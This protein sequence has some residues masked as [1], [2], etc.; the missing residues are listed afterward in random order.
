MKRFVLLVTLLNLSVLV[1]A[2]DFYYKLPKRRGHMTEREKAL[3]A[4]AELPET[5]RL[6]ITSAK[7]EPALNIA[8]E[9]EPGKPYYW[10]KVGIS[11]F[12][13]F[14]T[15]YNYYYYPQTRQIFYLDW[16]NADFQPI[17]LQQWRYWR[18]KPA[19]RKDHVYKRGKLMAKS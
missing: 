3:V 13:M 2:Q 9:P 14:R 7:S 17:S 4:I 15:T 6:F 19:W 18:T 12:D 10:I 1:L 16:V 5:K 11:N 8:G